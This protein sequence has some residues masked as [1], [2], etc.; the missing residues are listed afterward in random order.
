MNTDLFDRHREVARRYFLGCGAA[1]LAA[2]SASP[3]LGADPKV[4]PRSYSK[5]ST[6]WNPGSPS[7]TTSKMC[8]AGSQ[9]LTRWMK[10]SV[11][12]W[13]LTRE[14]PGPWTSPATGRIRLASAARCRAPTITRFD[15][16]T[17]WNLPKR[18]PSA[19]PKVMTCLNIGCPLGNGI[20]EGVPLREVIWRAQPTENLRRIH[21]YGYHNDDPKQMFRSSLPVGRVLEDYF[22]L[23]P[24]IL[25][26]KLNGQWL[27]PERGGPVRIVVPEAYGFKS[28]K[29]LSHLVLSNQW[30]ANDTY[31]EKNNDVST[32]RSKTFCDVLTTPISGK[33]QPAAGNQRLRPSGSRRIEQGAS[34]APAGK[35]ESWPKDDPLFPKRRHGGTPPS[36][37]R[38]P[39]GAEA[40]PT[41]EFLT[42]NERAST[43]KQA[44]R[45]SGRSSCPKRIGQCLLPGT[46]AGKISPAMPNDRR[47]RRRAT[48]AATVSKIGPGPHRADSK[49]PSNPDAARPANKRALRIKIATNHV[50]SSYD[51]VRCSQGLGGNRTTYLATAFFVS[52][53]AK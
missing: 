37:H 44:S 21:Y 50:G 30:S 4:A 5:R 51:M 23:P 36:Y 32:A 15:S 29:W 6:R 43:P 35:S 40:W 41:T 38:R 19:F 24:V 27:S 48:H 10:P 46:P 42:G 26:Y 9:S 20:W 53:V 12:R 25:C 3:L 1:G 18:M 13:G 2:L 22:G 14:T 47:Q 28:I 8:P 11:K 17:S 33:A 45:F 31:G 39:T 34:L 16:A 7:P 49:S 52:S